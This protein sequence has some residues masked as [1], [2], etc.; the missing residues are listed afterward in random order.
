MHADCILTDLASAEPLL[1]V[2]VR[3]VVSVV[4]TVIRNTH[5]SAE[6]AD[7]SYGGAVHF[8]NVSLANVVLEYGTVVGTTQNDYKLQPVANF[9][10]Y[11]GDDEEYDVDVLPVSVGDRG[12]FGEEFVLGVPEQN[13]SD[14]VF[15]DVPLDAIMP[16]CPPVSVQKRREIL[17]RGLPSSAAIDYREEY[18]AR[19]GEDVVA[20]FESKLLLPESPWL[21]AL[22]AELGP[23]PPAPPGWPPF[24]VPP[25][26]E[27]QNR[28]DL[29]VST[30]GPPA[31]P[32]WAPFELLSP[33]EARNWTERGTYM[34][35]YDRGSTRSTAEQ[36]M[37]GLAVVAVVLLAVAVAA[38]VWAAVAVRQAARRAASRPRMSRRYGALWMSAG[39]DFMAVRLC[40]SVL[41]LVCDLV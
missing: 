10:Y 3:S 6:I 38:S 29:S 25:P 12:M 13:M 1:G 5:L 21:V 30:Q 4:D 11:P 33:A 14:C 17:E 23:L 9:N 37:I 39:L 28:T 24:L 32:P 7:M 27:L 36:Q 31:R 34:P 18:D 20:E 41:A 2:H 35:G 8:S 40:L 22:R 26:A 16:G 15:T 19:V